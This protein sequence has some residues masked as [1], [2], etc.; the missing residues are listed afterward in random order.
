M[1]EKIVKCY[2][3]FDCSILWSGD[4][5]PILS[6]ISINSQK[7]GSKSVDKLARIVNS[8][9]IS[10]MTF[11]RESLI[12]ETEANLNYYPGIPLISVSGLSHL[13]CKNVKSLLMRLLF[14][15]VIRKVLEALNFNFISCIIYWLVFCLNRN[16]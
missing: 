15:N 7:R 12:I 3:H 14:F 1:I 13:L 4:W 16:M 9:L 5:I 6:T 2:L 10:R 11:P 8:K